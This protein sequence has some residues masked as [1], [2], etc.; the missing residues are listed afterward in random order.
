MKKE[1]Y[2][3]AAEALARLQS[4]P[5]WVAKRAQEEAERQRLAAETRRA[6]GDLV[7]DL[8]AAGFVLDSVWDLVNTASPYPA[9]IPI[10]L[11][12]FPRSYPGRVRE[13][14]AR[15]L[16]VRE[17]KQYWQRLLNWFRSEHDRHAKDG[18]AVALGVLA[19]DEHFDDVVQ[20]VRDTAH[21]TSRAFLLRAL[22]HSSRAAARTTL[23]QLADDPE[24]MKE[25]RVIL[26]RRKCED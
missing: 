19:D 7:S 21:G 8:R 13:G 11:E 3:T 20:I 26:K 1:K 5:E 14:I 25:V 17:A 24:L 18:L 9:A 6:E 4:D 12:H 2:V 23:E 16:A 15:A 22:E 10:L